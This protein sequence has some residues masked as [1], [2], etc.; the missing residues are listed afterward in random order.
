MERLVGRLLELA[1]LEAGAGQLQREP[2]SLAAVMAGLERAFAPQAEAQEVALA[3]RVEPGLP[4]VLGDRDRLAQLVGNLLDNALAHTPAGG[5]VRV[6]AGAQAGEVR[7]AVQDS[8]A[9]IPAEE[10][11]RIFERF[12]Q[13]DKSRGAAGGRASSGLGL[14]I[15]RQLAE[16]HGGRIEVESAPGQGSAFT[17]SLPA[18]RP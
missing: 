14:A 17:L 16:A 10:L 3:F 11:G 5:R 8:G 4:A 13:V 15:A 12:Y 7:L 18:Y 9:G 2:V 1:Q 6:T